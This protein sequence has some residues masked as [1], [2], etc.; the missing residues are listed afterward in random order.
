MTGEKLVL[1]A[2]EAAEVLGVSRST[3]VR[4]TA[5]GLLR[6]L[7]GF[8]ERRYGRAELA[9]YANGEPPAGLRAVAS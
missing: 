2:T 5:A 1:T 8:T 7:P 6:T 4:L 9:R 3:V